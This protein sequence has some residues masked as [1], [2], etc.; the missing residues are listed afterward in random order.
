M[1]EFSIR[2]L[3]VDDFEPFRQFVQSALQKLADVQVIAESS[4]GLDAVQK[5][6]ELQPDLILIDVGLPKLNGIEAVRR[7][8]QLSPSSRI[9]FVSENRSADVAQEALNNGGS[10]YLFKSDVTSELLAAVKAV[11]A[12]KR[13]ISANLT[14]QL[15]VATTMTSVQAIS[16][17][18]MLLSGIC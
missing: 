18:V 15:L 14:S 2:V 13:Y 12:G 16:W 17:I 6:Q 1:G 11:L 4:D 10:G 3:V 8:R 7:I 9:L 5:A